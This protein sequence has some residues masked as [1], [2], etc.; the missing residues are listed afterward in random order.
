MN[1]YFD[2]SAVLSSLLN[3]SPN[4][5]DWKKVKRG[6]SSALI[7][8][9]CNRVLDRYRLLNE[10]D[11]IELVELKTCFKRFTSALTIFHISPEIVQ[12][13]SESFPTI[14]GSLDSIHISTALEIRDNLTKN[15]IFVSDDKQQKI[16]AQALD[17]EIV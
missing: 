1:C 5:K 6:F 15:L 12:R 14:V 9:E 13:S 8:I 11:D 17:L 10:I 16:C 7:L 3:Q 4:F 2:S